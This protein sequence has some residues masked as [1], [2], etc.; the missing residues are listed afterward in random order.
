MTAGAGILH[1]ELSTERIWRHGGTMHGAQLWV[2]IPR[3]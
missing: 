2:N 3:R 1:D